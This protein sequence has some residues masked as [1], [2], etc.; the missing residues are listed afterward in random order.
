V[1]IPAEVQALALEIKTDLKEK[2]VPK[3]V[4]VVCNNDCY[5]Q[6]NIWL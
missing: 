4:K 5:C 6:K 3:A 2:E 1:E